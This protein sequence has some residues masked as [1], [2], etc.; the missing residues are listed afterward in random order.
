MRKSRS[1][2]RTRILRL[3]CSRQKQCC[4]FMKM[5][6]RYNVSEGFLGY[7][8]NIDLQGNENE[9]CSFCPI[10]AS[11]KYGKR[12]RY[13]CSVPCASTTAAWPPGLPTHARAHNSRP[14]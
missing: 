4:K 3:A 8:S 11:G 9:N 10:L 1:A 5:S 6:F 12:D 7:L 2:T 14:E 13:L